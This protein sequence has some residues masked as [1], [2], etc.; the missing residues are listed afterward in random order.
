M[1]EAT[2]MQ[3]DL[4]SLDEVVRTCDHL[5][6]QIRES[7]FEPEVVVAIARGGFTPARFLCDFLHIGALAA[8][9]VEHYTAGAQREEQA[10]VTIPLAA[11]I[12]DAQVLLVD[13]V[14]DSGDTLEAAIP[15]LETFSPAALRTAVLHEKADTTQPADFCAT[16]IK[17]WRWLLYPWA[18]VEDIGEFIRKMKPTGQSE[19]QI[20]QR[21]Q[22]QY[23]LQLSPQQLERVMRFM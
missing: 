6:Q 12:R 15:H 11:D 2:I 14:N 16:E 21:L 10:R 3:V 19:E 1:P 4:V 23:G 20:Q 7:D 8:I 18:V 22:Q 9:R 5:A 17:Q 13:D